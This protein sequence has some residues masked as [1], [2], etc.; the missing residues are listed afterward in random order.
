[1]SGSLVNMIH[2][3][4]LLVDFCVLQANRSHI[5][6]KEMIKLCLFLYL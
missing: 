3:I 5:L 2:T 1:M 4:Y 6:N